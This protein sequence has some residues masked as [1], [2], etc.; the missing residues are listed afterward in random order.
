[1]IESLRCAFCGAPLPPSPPGVMV[2]CGACSNVTS[3]PQLAPTVP[4]MPVV[5][6]SLGGGDFGATPPPSGLPGANVARAPSVGAPPPQQVLPSRAGGVDEL[7]GGGLTI[8]GISI[9]KLALFGLFSLV[10]ACV[11]G[12]FLSFFG[13]R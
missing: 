9:V 4:A 1:M 5:T 12:I 11:L 6:P 10:G 13:L 8:L 3:V 7:I 2:R